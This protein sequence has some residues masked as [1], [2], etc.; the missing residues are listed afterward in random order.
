MMYPGLVHNAPAAPRFSTPRGHVTNTA[1]TS[2]PVSYSATKRI[3]ERI[4]SA[5]PVEDVEGHSPDPAYDVRPVEG[6]G[7]APLRPERRGLGFAMDTI[8]AVRRSQVI[9]ARPSG[10]V[11]TAASPAESAASSP[12][13]ASAAS[14]PGMLPPSLSPTMLALLGAAAVL[15]LMRRK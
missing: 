14:V 1:P 5:L 10:L 7:W 2:R 13:S 11:Q 8:D 6:L 3:P 4:W 9:Q 12:S 15:M